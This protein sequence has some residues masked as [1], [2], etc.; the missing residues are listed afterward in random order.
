MPKDHKIDIPGH[1]MERINSDYSPSQ[2]R[3]KMGSQRYALTFV[4]LYTQ[5]VKKKEKYITSPMLADCVPESFANIIYANQILN[6]LTRIGILRKIKVQGT[7]VVKFIFAEG[8]DR[9]GLL[10]IAIKT[11]DEHD[12]NK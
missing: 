1:I 11:L 7:K 8:F 10:Q 5:F 4:W 9:E 2:A 6:Y 3:S 12:G